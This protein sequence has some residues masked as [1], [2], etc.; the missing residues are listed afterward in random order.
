M[1][2]D[3][4]SID[5]YLWLEEVEGNAAL[6]W[7]QQQNERSLASIRKHAGSGNLH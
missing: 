7:V 3:V 1:K 4:T 6:E 2:Q 5:P